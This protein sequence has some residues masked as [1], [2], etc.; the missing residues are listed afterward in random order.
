M[1]V[2]G[3]PMKNLTNFIVIAVITIVFVINAYFIIFAPERGH[4][5][6][7]LI[8]GKNHYLVIKNEDKTGFV[9]VSWDVYFDAENGDIYDT[10]CDC[11]VGKP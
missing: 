4:V 11:I 8:S 3:E 2:C 7:R 1:Y 9:W 5:A 10:E 6:G